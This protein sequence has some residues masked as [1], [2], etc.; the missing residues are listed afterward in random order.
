MLQR[1]CFIVVFSYEGTV[2][3][4]AYDGLACHK[5]VPTAQS[6]HNVS[7]KLNTSRV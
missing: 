1:L 6:L 5:D 3:V 4:A 7:G 2:T